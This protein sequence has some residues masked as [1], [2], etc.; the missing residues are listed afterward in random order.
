MSECRICDI[1]KDRSS[2]I[3]LESEKFAAISDARPITKGHTVVVPKKHIIS[4]F[5]VADEDTCDLHIFLK[6]VK[7]ILDENHSPDGYNIGVNDGKAAGRSIDHLHI[8]LIPRYMGDVSEPK[9]GVRHILG[10]N[11][12]YEP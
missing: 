8:H 12:S 6:E 7:K 10:R 11:N 3:I 1:L 9:G 2:E 5:D 4:F